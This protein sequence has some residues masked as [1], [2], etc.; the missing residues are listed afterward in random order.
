MACYCPHIRC[1]DCNNYGYVAMDCPD[2]ILPSGTPS[3]HR[4]NNRDR[5]KR[6]S[7]RQPSHTRCLCH[8]HRS[9]SRFSRS[10]PCNHSYQSSSQHEHCRN[11]SRCSID[12]PIAAPHAI[13]APAHIT[14]IETLHTQDL[15]ATTLLGTTADPGITPNTTHYK[16]AQGSS[17]TTQAPSQKYKDKRQKPKKFPLTI[18]SQ[19]TVQRKVK[20]TQRMI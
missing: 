10:C 8:D 7:S 20:A 18:L 4:T 17:S 11:H 16:P 15:L 3:P 1:Y 12:I 2:K 6:S 5:N 13:E 9:R 19:I 14:I